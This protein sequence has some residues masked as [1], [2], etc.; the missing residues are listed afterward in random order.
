[1]ESK[2]WVYLITIEGKGYV[3]ISSN[4]RSRYKK[5]INLLR[6]NTHNN[7]RMQLAYNMAGGKHTYEILEEVPW[8]EAHYYEEDWIYRLETYIATKGFNDKDPRIISAKTHKYTKDFFER[9]LG[10]NRKHRWF[11]DINR[12][13][14]LIFNTEV[15]CLPSREV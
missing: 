8:G 1:M 5:H 10:D 7:E 3:G 2:A 12:R 13:D 4:P 14:R 9:M 6:N 15:I 11:V